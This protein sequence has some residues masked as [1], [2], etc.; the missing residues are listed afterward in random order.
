MF[1]HDNGDVLGG[2]AVFFAGLKI[3]VV[4]SVIGAVVGE[5][6]S[7]DK[8]LG[9]LINLA[10]G[11]YDTPLRFAAFFSLSIIALLLYFSIG[12]LEKLFIKWK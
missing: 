2:L 5:F 9:Y 7:A 12:I 3:G 8:G 11:L 4:L 6:V 1:F 10:S